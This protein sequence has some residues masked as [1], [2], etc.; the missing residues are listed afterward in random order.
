MQGGRGGAAGGA[1]GAGM[2]APGMYSMGAPPPLGYYS[3][4][5]P[6]N[7]K[8][9]AGRASRGQG[10]FQTGFRFPTARANPN[11]EDQ[12]IESPHLATARKSVHRP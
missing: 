11:E 4:P 6:M 9:R 1:G 3:A 7:Q 8:T 2:G 12:H 10:T 5:Q